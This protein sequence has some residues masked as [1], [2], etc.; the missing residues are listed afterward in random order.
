MD[1]VMISARPQSCA[2]KR[3]GHDAL[4]TATKRQRHAASDLKSSPP[5]LIQTLPGRVFGETKLIQRMEEP[6]LAGAHS[7]EVT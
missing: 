3:D 7:R 1:N 5:I 4:R 2:E 6:A